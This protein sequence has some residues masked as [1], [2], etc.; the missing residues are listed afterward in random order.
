M[1]FSPCL[2]GPS[3]ESCCTSPDLSLFPCQGGLIL[4]A[5]RGASHSNQRGPHQCFL[6]HLCLIM[7]GG[8]VCFDEGCCLTEFLGQKPLSKGTNGWILQGRADL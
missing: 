7:T 3:F 6:S 1:W 2:H 8:I 5:V 4:R